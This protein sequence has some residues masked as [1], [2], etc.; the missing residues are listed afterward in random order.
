MGPERQIIE[1]GLTKLRRY[2]YTLE[3]ASRTQTGEVEKRPEA[4][5]ET[6]RRLVVLST[7]LANHIIGRRRLPTPSDP[8]DIFRVLGQANFLPIDLAER[9]SD[10]AKL[11]VKLAHGYQDISPEDMQ[12]WIPHR[13]S[14]LTVFADCVAEALWER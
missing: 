7:N 8:T 12:A 1:I 3:C 9:L 10:V 14:D 5:E 4:V 13:L 2:I 11:R 6:F